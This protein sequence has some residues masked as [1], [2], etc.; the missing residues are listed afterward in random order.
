MNTKLSISKINNIGYGLRTKLQENNNECS[1][2]LKVNLLNTILARWYKAVSLRLTL[3]EQRGS[4]IGGGAGSPD[5]PLLQLLHVLLALRGLLEPLGGP[6]LWAMPCRAP[7]HE[8]G[9]QRAEARI[10]GY[11]THIMLHPGTNNKHWSS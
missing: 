2:N 6:P 9:H 5:A 3:C 7:G 8:A 4:V 1:D 11:H 10:H